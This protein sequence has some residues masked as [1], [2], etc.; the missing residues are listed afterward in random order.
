M[1]VRV[2]QSF[3]VFRHGSF[4]ILWTGSLVSNIG[5]WMETVALGRYVQERTGEA[6]WAGLVAAA[7]FVPTAVV[8]L[9]GGALADRVSRQKLIIGASLAQASIAAVLAWMV[10]S[11]RATPG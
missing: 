6:K 11:G 9:L 7:G 3:R 2:P 5:T 8:G 1:P 4:A 10:A